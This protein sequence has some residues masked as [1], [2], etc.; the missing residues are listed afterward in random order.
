[1]EAHP[2]P[3]TIPFRGPVPG[4]RRVSECMGVKVKRG[5][6]PLTK[7]AAPRQVLP[8]NLRGQSSRNGE[9]G[10]RDLTP[11]GENHRRSSCN[12]ELRK[13]IGIAKASRTPDDLDPG[14]YSRMTRQSGTELLEIAEKF[15]KCNKV[16]RKLC[17]MQRKL[18]FTFKESSGCVDTLGGDLDRS[19]L[20]SCTAV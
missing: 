8:H 20:N 2:G 15:A 14:R 6:G 4:S 16:D 11:R 1:M 9:R 5:A 17:N 19:A 13:D 10:P 3:D 18:L 12:L 7:R